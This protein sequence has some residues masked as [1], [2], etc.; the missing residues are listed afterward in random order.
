MDT[1][2]Q[3]LQQLVDEL[4]ELKQYLIQSVYERGEV[5]AEYDAEVILRRIRENREKKANEQKA[6]AS[7]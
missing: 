7:T 6:E 2:T 4:R 1:N 5:L 3:L